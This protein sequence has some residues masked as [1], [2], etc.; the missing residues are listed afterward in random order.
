MS[1]KISH[2]GIIDR[3]DVAAGL[4]VVRIVQTTACAACKMAGH[5]NASESKVKTIDVRCGKG[6]AQ[7]FS[8][9]QP[10]TVWASRNVAGRSLLLG[11]GLPFVVLVGVL[12]AVLT[13]S[14][15]E[16]LAALMGIGALVPYYGALWLLR[17]RI[18]SRISFH[19]EAKS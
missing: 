8:V 19:L 18:A 10:V 12:V 1:D 2:E 3:I 4:V 6:V 16:A 14:G 15:S 5:C 17:E 7:F 9:G 13:L 11:F